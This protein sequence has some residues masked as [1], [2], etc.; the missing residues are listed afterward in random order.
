MYK[1]DF[2]NRYNKGKEAEK[3]VLP[4]IRDY[5]KRDIV[6]TTLKTDRYDYTCSNYKYELKTRSNVMDKYPTTMIGYDKLEENVILLFKFTDN[7]IAYIEYNEEQFKNYKV[8]LF[9][10][11]TVPKKHIYIPI[12]DLTLIDDCHC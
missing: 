7:K 4:I 1:K 3:L 10:K 12:D 6:A 8:E 11:Y 2:N 5:F 9:T